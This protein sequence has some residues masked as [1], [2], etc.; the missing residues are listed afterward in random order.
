[1][2]EN[3]RT[4]ELSKGQYGILRIGLKTENNQP[5]SPPIKELV[6]SKYNEEDNITTKL[7]RTKDIKE[8]TTGSFLY[9]LSPEHLQ[10]DKQIIEAKWRFKETNNKNEPWI[11]LPLYY[12]CESFLPF[13]NSLSISMKEMIELINWNFSGLHDNEEA[14]LPN[15]A[16]QWQTVYNYETLAN[17]LKM[18]IQDYNTIGGYPLRHES[19][20]QFGGDRDVLFLAF[21]V[22]V[23]K[24]FI[25]SYVE[26]FSVSGSPGVAWADISSFADRWRAL[27]RDEE[28]QLKDAMNAIIIDLKYGVAGAQVVRGGL[29]GGRYSSGIWANNTYISELRGSA[30]EPQFHY[31]VV[32]TE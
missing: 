10:D 4:Q 28:Q 27:L 19:L 13:Y 32:I 3:I 29:F 14:S 21:R 15:F 22:R 20:E 12:K 31:T 7:F 24:Y 11:E 1:M 2:L 9:K 25:T 8:T 18:A 23:I 26:E 16:S 5:Y 17:L 30:F 6:I